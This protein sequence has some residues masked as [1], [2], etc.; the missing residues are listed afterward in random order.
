MNRHCIFCICQLLI[1]F[2]RE[3]V[4]MLNKVLISEYYNIF[5]ILFYNTQFV[6]DE[7]ELPFWPFTYIFI[8]I[9]GKLSPVIR[10]IQ[11]NWEFINL[12]PLIY[13]TRNYFTLKFINWMTCLCHCRAI[14]YEIPTYFCMCHIVCNVHIYIVYAW[15]NCIH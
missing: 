14:S 5:V 10:K 12:P 9:Y 1:L 11:T 7:N 13:L 8:Y 15:L 3:I 6:I 2:T 4:A